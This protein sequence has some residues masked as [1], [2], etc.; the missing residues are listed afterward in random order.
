MP[1]AMKLTAARFLIATSAPN[2][3]VRG[4]LLW[5]ATRTP[6]AAERA[7]K[8]CEV[9]IWTERR[10]RA[11]TYPRPEVRPC[12][13]PVHSGMEAAEAGGRLLLLLSCAMQV[14]HV[15]GTYISMRSAGFGVLCGE[16]GV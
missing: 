6:W 9:P 16:H 15:R 3:K 7:S 5:N 11:C 10:T 12:E 8:T 1:Q 4:P 13:R 14:K 2:A